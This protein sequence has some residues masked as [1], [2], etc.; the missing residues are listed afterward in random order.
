MLGYAALHRVCE[1]GHEHVAKALLD[2]KY[3]G[4]GATIDLRNVGGS[5]PLMCAIQGHESVV[6]LLLSRGAKQELQSDS[7]F[8][9]LHVAVLGD[10][11]GVI[12]L[13]CTAPGAAAALAPS[14]GAAARRAGHALALS[15]R[16]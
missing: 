6:R 10:R 8:T 2:G 11:P 13:L 4:R 16:S 7:G 15:P 9:A 3:E 1:P 14:G 5:T 12:A